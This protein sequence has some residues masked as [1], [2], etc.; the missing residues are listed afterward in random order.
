MT[1]P[2]VEI[3]QTVNSYQFNNQVPGGEELVTT[4]GDTNN[5]ARNRNSIEIFTHY[6]SVDKINVLKNFLKKTTRNQ[7]QVTKEKLKMIDPKNYP[8]YQIERI[9][10]SVIKKFLYIGF[11][12]ILS[13][14]QKHNYKRLI[15]QNINDRYRQN[16][17][18]ITGKNFHIWRKVTK[19]KKSLKFK[20]RATAREIYYFV[21]EKIENHRKSAFQV[22]FDEAREKLME[23][24]KIN[25][26]KNLVLRSIFILQKIFV[27]KKIIFKSEAVRILGRRFEM[28]DYLKGVF[29]LEK[30]FRKKYFKVLILKLSPKIEMARKLSNIFKKLKF[31]IKLNKAI[32]F[33]KL[34][35]CAKLL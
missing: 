35:S 6:I 34:T 19:T 5:N 29:F 15:L 32:A 31:L 7:E 24:Q 28:F 9:I 1:E 12:K 22:I 18:L 20:L 11:H 2:H 16:I 25:D 3:N 21:F 14:A 26:Y 30:T 17:M 10:F 4:E 23:Q 33:Y 13:E 27:K 8:H